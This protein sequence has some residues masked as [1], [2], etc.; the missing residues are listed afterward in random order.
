MHCRT[1]SRTGRKNG[2]RAAPDE[3]EQLGRRQY[4]NVST[5]TALVPVNNSTEVCEAARTDP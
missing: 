3:G 4:A 5:D 2:S 1:S